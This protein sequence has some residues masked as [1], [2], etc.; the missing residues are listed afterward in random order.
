MSSSIGKN[1]ALSTTCDEI[2][3]W[4]IESWMN[5]HLV[6]DN[7]CNTVNLQSP[8]IKKRKRVARNENEVG[9]TFRVGDLILWF[10]I[11]IEQDN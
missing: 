7:Y 3:S 1:L 6:I 11:K 5:N 10:T 4:M 9:L 2:L 8:Q